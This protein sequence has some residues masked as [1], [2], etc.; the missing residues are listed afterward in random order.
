MVF[1]IKAEC[2]KSTLVV[3]V[4]LLVVVVVVVVVVVGTGGTLSPYT[5]LRSKE[6]L[7]NFR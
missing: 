3:I 4:L 1:W 5:S 2:F 7:C 6:F